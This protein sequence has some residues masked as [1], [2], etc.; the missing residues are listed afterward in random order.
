LTFLN[1]G[2]NLIVGSIP[3]SIQF[4]S[5]LEELYLQNNKLNGQI[6]PQLG[7]LKS[8]KNIDLS[9]L[10][11]SGCFPENWNKKKWLTCILTGVQYNCTCEAPPF[12]T[13]TPCIMPPQT[14][15]S[16]SVPLPVPLYLPLPV[17][18]PSQESPQ[19]VFSEP[20]P[21]VNLPNVSDHVPADHVPYNVPEAIVSESNELCEGNICEDGRECMVVSSG[22][23]CTK[24]TFG[25]VEDGPFKC[26]LHILSWLIPPVII[27][28]VVIAIVGILLWRKWQSSQPK[29]SLEDGENLL[30]SVQESEPQTYLNL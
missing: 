15:V 11:L 12:C 29:S 28:L 9:E 23:N 24:C 10:E 4:L 6:P 13:T 27:L 25:Y 26:K 1:F 19:I 5:N 18:L 22:Y 30:E 14:D 2:S 3:S 21:N 8:L 17:P 20:A 16:L 7:Y